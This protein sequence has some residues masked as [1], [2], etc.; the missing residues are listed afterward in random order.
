[1]SK[2]AWSRFVHGC[3]ETCANAQCTRERHFHEKKL[4]HW[5]R[6]EH[7][8]FHRKLVYFGHAGLPDEDDDDV[9]GRRSRNWP[10]E[11]RV[12]VGRRTGKTF[13][14]SPCLA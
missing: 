7:R 4:A 11:A 5:L 6:K 1:M 8:L 14:N 2:S 13:I 3:A 10:G 12:A 9:R